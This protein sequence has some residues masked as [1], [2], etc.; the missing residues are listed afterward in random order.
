MPPRPR[1]L[2]WRIRRL[3]SQR[4]WGSRGGVHVA[5]DSG[6]PRRARRCRAISW[7]CIPT[8]NDDSDAAHRLGSVIRARWRLYIVLDPLTSG[9]L[10]GTYGELGQVRCKLVGEWRGHGRLAPLPWL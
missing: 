3:V 6:E 2:R 4:Y 1:I 5:L 9:R 8:V 7:E 10:A